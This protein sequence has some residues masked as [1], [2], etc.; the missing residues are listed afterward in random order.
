MNHSWKS[1]VELSGWKI[2]L[3]FINFSQWFFMVTL[4]YLQFMIMKWVDMNFSIDLPCSLPVGQYQSSK[5]LYSEVASYEFCNDFG[6]HFF[7][8]FDK[9]TCTKVIAVLT[10]RNVWVICSL[11]LMQLYKSPTRETRW[12]NPYYTLSRKIIQAKYGE[13]SFFGKYLIKYYAVYAKVFYP[14]TFQ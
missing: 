5:N 13:K 2:N 3:R 9:K 6:S 14:N 1:P 4:F 11:V 7:M 10:I 8:I 12:K